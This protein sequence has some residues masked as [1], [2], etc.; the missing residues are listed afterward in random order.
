[1]YKRRP[2]LNNAT[3]VL[4]HRVQLLEDKS[5]EDIY[6]F[7]AGRVSEAMN[8]DDLFSKNVSNSF[9]MGYIYHLGA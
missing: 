5:D 1:M 8:F 6:Y 9:M 2:F 4:P 7:P 3:I